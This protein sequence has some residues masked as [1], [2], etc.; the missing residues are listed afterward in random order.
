[1]GGF[2]APRLCIFSATAAR[3]PPLGKYLAYNSRLCYDSFV[4]KPQMTEPSADESQTIV[5][6][7]D[8]LVVLDF[9]RTTLEGAGYKVFTASNGK[10][11]LNLFEPNR[12]PIDLALID[13]VMPGMS[14]VELARRIEEVNTNTRIVFMSG[15]SPEEVKRVVGEDAAQY[16]SMWKPFE[17]R[18]LVQM[19]KNALNGAA[20]KRILVDRARVAGS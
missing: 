13:L 18:T 3:S 14:G 11:A 19:I 16:P 17:P 7:D 10:D 8:Q 5:V 15:F 4:G 6:V 2:P 1:M 20:P 12:S 9:C